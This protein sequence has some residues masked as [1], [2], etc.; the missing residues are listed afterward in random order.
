VARKPSPAAVSFI[1][2]TNAI[3]S[4]AIASAIAVAAAFD[5]LT[6]AACSSV[7]SGT[8]SPARSGTRP[9]GVAAAYG[10]IAIVSPAAM[11]P[12]ASAS[13]ARYSVISLTRLAGARAS[14]PWCATIRAPSPSRTIAAA[15]VSDPMP[16]PSSRSRASSAR[17]AT[18]PSE[19]GRTLPPTRDWGLGIGDWGLG[20]R[21]W[22][23]PAGWRRAA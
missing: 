21:R 12:D 11:R 2:A 18:R 7:R 3:S 22:G 5:D 13:N 8:R 14:S 23:S 20:I 4:P 19:N 9:C 15:A 6:A 16:L 1:R 10:L 17:R